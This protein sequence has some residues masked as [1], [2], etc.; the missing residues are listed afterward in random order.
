MNLRS[1][2]RRCN[3]F[4]SVT[5]AVQYVPQST[6]QSAGMSIYKA[7]STYLDDESQMRAFDDSL[8]DLVDEADDSHK[9][10]RGWGDLPL[11]FKMWVISCIV[12]TT[13]HIWLFRESQRALSDV[14]ATA[15]MWLG[16]AGHQIECAQHGL[17]GDHACPNVTVAANT[18]FIAWSKS[19]VAANLELFYLAIGVVGVS[20]LVT[21]VL[22]GWA[23]VT[24]VTRRPTTIHEWRKWHLID[25]VGESVL[26][27]LGVVLFVAK[28]RHYLV[29]SLS[30]AGGNYYGSQLCAADSNGYSR[31]STT[32]RDDPSRIWMQIL[33][34][35]GLSAA[36]AED[37]CPQFKLLGTNFADVDSSVDGM[38]SV[39]ACMRIDNFYPCDRTV[40]KRYHTLDDSEPTLAFAMVFAYEK[41]FNMYLCGAGLRMPFWVKAPS[42]P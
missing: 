3:T 34:P 25:S 11:Q 23:V 14:S 6:R 33:V 5:P 2:R 22:C 17:G 36:Q 31:T 21:M 12:T 40:L 24:I 18:E 10:I 30:E 28:L 37:V 32:C 1:H 42:S 39:S 41:L 38:R 8:T 9:I 20:V 26:F 19:C 35:V 27:I 16:P 13:A 29:P 15:Q 4:T 7:M